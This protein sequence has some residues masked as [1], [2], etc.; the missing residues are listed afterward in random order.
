MLS[1]TSAIVSLIALIFRAFGSSMQRFSRVLMMPGDLSCG[2]R[3]RS[4]FVLALLCWP[5]SMRPRQHDRF[6]F[7]GLC[8]LYRRNKFPPP[9]VSAIVNRPRP[10]K[11]TN[12]SSYAFAGCIAIYCMVSL[13]LLFSAPSP[14]VNGQHCDSGK[15]ASAIEGTHM[16][17]SPGKFVNSA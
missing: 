16:Y 10:G 11:L 5:L 17:A 9:P 1:A 6:V 4:L 14:V 12:S 15:S 2:T 7:V 8:W 13:L 3:T